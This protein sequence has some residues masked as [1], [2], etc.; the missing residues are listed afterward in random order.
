M[1]FKK[2]FSINNK[3]SIIRRF[4]KI[5]KEVIMDLREKKTKRN[6]RNAFIKLRAKKPLER[7]SIKELAELAEISKATFY[8]HYKDIYDLSENLQKEVIENVLSCI[9]RSDLFL[10][11]EVQ[12]TKE[13]F[14]AFHSQQ[15][16]IEILFSDS[17]SAILPIH[18]EKAL[19][20]YIFKQIPEYK[21]SARFNIMLSYR[22]QGGYHA[23]QENYKR[24]SLNDITDTITYI[25]KDA[26]MLEWT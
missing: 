17:Q 9:S 4:W 22:I 23:Y 18:I 13:L 7:I 2:P 19:K 5:D 20:D 21:D 8:L 10:T 16:L 15:T 24:F 25:N 1:V 26:T 14:Q 3:D 6:I 12:F 11:D